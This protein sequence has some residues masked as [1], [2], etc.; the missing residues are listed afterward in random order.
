MVIDNLPGTVGPRGLAAPQIAYW[1]SMLKR[2]TDTDERKANLEKRAWA[3]SLTGSAGSSREL[4]LQYDEMRVGL[5]E[6]GL[7]KN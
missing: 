4:K 7:A 2:M 6:L 3:N 5:A 1:E